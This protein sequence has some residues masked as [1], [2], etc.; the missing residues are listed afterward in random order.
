MGLLFG[1]RDL[2]RSPVS[3]GC[4][5][6]SKVA[7]RPAGHN[8]PAA[9]RTGFLPESRGS[10][11]GVARTYGAKR[12]GSRDAR[13][14][15]AHWERY[16]DGSA[17]AAAAS[18]S[19]RT[20]VSRHAHGVA[21]RRRPRGACRGERPRPRSPSDGSRDALPSAASA[22]LTG[23]ARSGRPRGLSPDDARSQVHRPGKPPA[24]RSRRARASLARTRTTVQ[25]RSR[26][27]LAHT[28]R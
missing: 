12:A 26:P 5:A 11:A 16:D 25:E 21:M 9:I 17:R 4:P 8:G 1:S 24:D 10:T 19:H 18:S 27:W 3:Q 20:R 22:A 28:A 7:Q 15:S 14:A 23:S 2:D 13:W 6:A